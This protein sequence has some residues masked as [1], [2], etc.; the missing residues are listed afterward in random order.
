MKVTEAEANHTVFKYA[1]RMKTELEYNAFLQLI[2][3]YD[4]LLRFISVQKLSYKPPKQAKLPKTFEQSL[5]KLIKKDIDNN[6]RLESFKL[7]LQQ[8]TD[9]DG[10]VI[11]TMIDKEDMNSLGESNVREYL[12]ERGLGDVSE[13]FIK[14]LDIDMDGKL[15]YNEF[16][17]GILPY[18]N[19]EVIKTLKEYPMIT[20][21]S[22]LNTQEKQIT[23]S[24]YDSKFISSSAKQHTSD[25]FS[26][27]KS[28]P[29]DKEY[30]GDEEKSEVYSKRRVVKH[31]P[32]TAK[33]LEA[34]KEQLRIESTLEECKNSIP[35]QH[36]FNLYDAFR[37]ID[38]TDKSFVTA[39]EFKDAFRDLGIEAL[40]ERYN[41]AA[42]GKF[43]YSDF[44]SMMLPK[45]LSESYA[46]NSRKGKFVPVL[47]NKAMN[48]FKKML[49]LSIDLEVAGETVRTALSPQ[50]DLRSVL[51][52][53]DSQ[54]RG[55]VSLREVSD[56]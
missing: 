32:Q 27:L 29:Y 11:F 7:S 31:N 26:P 10:F 5:A 30:V 16:L 1:A 8:A 17:E 13:M 53:L 15:V 36:D 49:K 3:P 39:S 25:T 44:C 33:L 45:E 20:E 19:K 6:N 14:G 24:D 34:I 28:S 52:E 23:E 22:T 43:Q 18:C 48:T 54:G 41:K 37:M 56:D 50:F 21:T 46:I 12:E 38:T 47:S 35:K 2:L 40:Y 9:F 55:Y 4:S 42:D 51:K